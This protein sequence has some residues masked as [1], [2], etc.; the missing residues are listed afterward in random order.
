M[1]AA[2]GD[3]DIE[4]RFMDEGEEG[5]GERNGESTV[6]AYTLPYKIDQAKWKSAV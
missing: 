2:V 4:N 6:E 3:T 1:Q 5:E